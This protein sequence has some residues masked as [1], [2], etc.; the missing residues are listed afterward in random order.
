MERVNQQVIADQLGISRTTVSRCFTNHPGINPE[1]R[2]RVF[3]LATRLGYYYLEPRTGDVVVRQ[4]PTT[5]GVLICSDLEEYYRADYESPGMELL[6]GVS[7]CFQLEQVQLDMHFV[8]PRQNAITDPSYRAIR[9]LRKRLWKGALL[10]YPFPPA[11]IRE[12]S[13]R[14]PCVSL[15][16]Q[17]GSTAIDCVDVNHYLGISELIDR[18]LAAGHRRIGFFSRHYPVEAC[19]AFR[20]FSAYV[21]KLTRAEIPIRQDDIINMTQGKDATLEEGYQHLLHQTRQGVT[22]WVCAA[23]HIAYEVIAQLGHN[24]FKVP[25][26]VSVTGFDGI[27]SPAGAPD[28]STVQVPYRQVGFTGAKRLCDMIRK[29]FDLTQHIL[30]ECRVHEGKTIGPVP[31][32][33]TARPARARR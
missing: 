33:M 23:D 29:R 1:T 24:G 4:N 17:Y 15:V 32:R 9:G 28:L 7:E 31:G 20:R 3:E 22:A 21:E 16:E 8:D 2:A 10:V 13:T 6:P 11:V 18:L 14:L 5:V 27:K 30:L 26:D 19:W 25:R 12:L